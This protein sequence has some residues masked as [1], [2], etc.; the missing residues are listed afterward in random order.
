M[1]CGHCGNKI[2]SEGRFCT[3][4]GKE[5]TKP[6]SLPVEV[7]EDPMPPISKQEVK[8][9]TY[10]APQPKSKENNNKLIGIIGVTLA[11]LVLIL[12]IALFFFL[13]TSYVEVPDFTGLNENEVIV[14]IEESGL[15]LWE[16]TEEYNHRVGEGL[17]IS[18][19]LRRGSEVERG[20]TINLVISLGEFAIED[21]TEDIDDLALDEEEFYEDDS[22]EVNDEHPE[23][24]QVLL[25][26]EDDISPWLV[27]SR[28]TFDR[29][30]QSIDDD[31]SLSAEEKDE[32]KW[33]LI[34]IVEIMGGSVLWMETP[35]GLSVIGAI[36]L[37][38]PVLV[39]IGL[40]SYDLQI[41]PEEVMVI[42]MDPDHP[43]WSRTLALFISQVS[44]ERAE[45]MAKLEALYTEH[46]ELI[47][48]RYGDEFP[49]FTLETPVLE[50]PVI[51]MQ[52]LVIW[53]IEAR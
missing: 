4:C 25:R 53:E 27:S 3:G 23:D 12:G 39:N 30:I 1:F 42:A 2:E 40:A 5:S 14:L 31:T 50:L 46:F 9:E 32:M 37:F 41:E 43:H 8:Q 22:Q 10:P 28:E 52:N 17:V 48:D 34:D 44:D 19:S 38:N 51:I 33:L 20:S 49:T 16:I 35:S 29:A 15:T 13:R 21:L 7:I 18:Q 47:W 45:Y 26:F 6:A 36:L 24:E 11:V